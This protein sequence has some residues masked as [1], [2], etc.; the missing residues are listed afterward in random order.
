MY[1]LSLPSI[2]GNVLSLS[3]CPVCHLTSETPE[4]QAPFL[5]GSY[6]FGQPKAKSSAD[7]K[8]IWAWCQGHS[9]I[10]KCTRSH[11]SESQSCIYTSVQCESDTFKSASD[12][13]KPIIIDFPNITGIQPSVFIESFKSLILVVHITHKDV[14]TV[15]T[16]L[17]TSHQQLVSNYL[18]KLSQTIT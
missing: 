18:E 1:N 15:N 12:V 2:N 9:S 13:D 16:H 3:V 10:T 4:L 7:V 8:V 11:S 14:T 17:S 6:I 5:L